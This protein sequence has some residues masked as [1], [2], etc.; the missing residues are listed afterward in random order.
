MPVFA[1]A[2]LAVV[3]AV[4]FSAGRRARVQSSGYLGAGPRKALMQGVW[5]ASD[6]IVSLGADDGQRGAPPSLLR[7]VQTEW[8]ALRRDAARLILAGRGRGVTYPTL[9]E[10]LRRLGVMANACHVACPPLTHCTEP[11]APDQRQLAEFAMAVR[12]VRRALQ[13]SAALPA[14]AADAGYDTST[15]VG[16]TRLANGQYEIH[17][18]SR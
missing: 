4:A 2:A 15:G 5:R 12:R 14:V 9:R 11:V 7:T 1:L 16:W 17:R 10:G 6:A 8:T 3:A 18:A 13:A